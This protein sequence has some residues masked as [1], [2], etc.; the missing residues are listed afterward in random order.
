MAADLEEVQDR[1]EVI[2]RAK[3]AGVVALI[4]TGVSCASLL[5]M[6]R[7]CTA[8]QKRTAP[9]NISSFRECLN[10]GMWSLLQKGFMTSK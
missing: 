8:V 2:A 6:P 7:S 10:E 4:I 3:K 5:A 1:E 9:E